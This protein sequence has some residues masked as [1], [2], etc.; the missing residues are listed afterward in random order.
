MTKPVQLQDLACLRAAVGYLG[1]KE[2]FN[3]WP[4]SFFGP[5]SSAFLTPV[6]SRT[7]LLA[8]LTAVTT[9]AARLHD[10][11]IGVGSNWHLF[12][13]P[14]DLEQDLHAFYAGAA[15]AERLNE[16]TK[17]PEAALAYLQQVQMPA[18][19]VGPK[20]MGGIEDLRTAAAW[21][22]VAAYYVAAFVGNGR[23]Y[24]YFADRTA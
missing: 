8:R 3:W 17:A 6:F 18:P 14:E 24:P 11:F 13:L 20:H 19:S 15:N 1:E 4:S 12:R 16:I 5:G 9:A 2:Q 7:A 10:E 23:T 22:A 21:Q